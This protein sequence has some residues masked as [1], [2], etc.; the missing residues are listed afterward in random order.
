MREVRNNT[1]FNFFTKRILIILILFVLIFPFFYPNT[2]LRAFSEI[3]DSNYNLEQIGNFDDN[4]GLFRSMTSNDDFIF[5]G[6]EE[7]IISIQKETPSTVTQIYEFPSTVYYRDIFVQGDRCYEVCNNKFR[8]FTIQLDGSLTMISENTILENLPEYYLDNVEIFVE[9]NFAYITNWEEGITIFDIGNPLKI[10]KVGNYLDESEQPSEIWVKDRYIYS[11]DGLDGLKILNATDPTKIVKVFQEL[12][13]EG[14]YTNDLYVEDEYTYVTGNNQAKFR[15]YNTSDL[16]N[17]TKI[18]SYDI[19]GSN[20]VIKENRAFIDQGGEMTILDISN[21]SAIELLSNFYYFSYFTFISPAIL[22]YFIEGNILYLNDIV[23]GLFTF[24]IAEISN[25]SFLSLLSIGGISHSIAF[26]EDFIY[27]AE[28]NLGIEKI[29][30]TDPKNPEK[31]GSYYEGNNGIA[32]NILIENGYLYLANNNGGFEIWDIH[33]ESS[34]TQVGEYRQGEN[35]EDLYIENNRAYLNA[36][37]SGIVILDI[38][39]KEEPTRLGAY[40]DAKSYNEICAK[41]NYLYTLLIDDYSN[42]QLKVIDVSDTINPTTVFIYH[43][44]DTPRVLKIDLK[45]DNLF[46]ATEKELIIFDLKNPAI[47]KLQEKYEPSISQINDIYIGKD[48]AVLGGLGIVVLDISKLKDINEYARFYDG[49]TISGIAVKEDLIYTSAELNNLR[50]F[51][52][53]TLLEYSETNGIELGTL[54]IFPV[55][56]IINIIARKKKK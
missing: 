47:P 33:K 49:S 52:A 2:K 50:I 18:V 40:F 21:L 41:E 45:K 27:L 56:L 7:S 22:D 39:N 37:Q 15:I 55:L 10:E 6:T 32:K 26:Y 28:D 35:I 1:K 14:E 44:D 17:V 11:I 4:Y 8:I 25:I 3:S 36:G 43:L 23:Y 30:I 20:V 16:L 42:K 12:I 48:Y 54:T 31:I 5:V 53:S 19:Y 51:Q 46:L 29:D 24:D 34:V 9:G 38:T 13:S